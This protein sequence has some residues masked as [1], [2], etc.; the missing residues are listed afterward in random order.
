[1]A[2]V[3]AVGE[4]SGPWREQNNANELRE[5]HRPNPERGSRQPIEQQRERDVLKPRPTVRE[6]IPRK[7]EGEVPVA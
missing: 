2:A 3:D 5:V 1:M 6:K 4:R 7:K